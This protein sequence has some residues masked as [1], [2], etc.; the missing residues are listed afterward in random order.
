PTDDCTFWYTQ[1]YYQTTGSFDFNTRICSFKFADCGEA[2]VPDETPEISCTD[3]VDNDCDNL[4]DCS[5]SDCSDDPACICDND[6]VCETGEDCN[7]CSNDCI[8]G[9]IPGAVCGNGICEAGD[10]E[11]CLSCAADCNGTQNGRPSN[12]FCCGDGDGQNPVSC[13]DSRCTAGG[14]MCTDVPTTPGSYCCGDAT[15]EGAE[16][17]FNCEIDCGAAPFCGDGTCDPGEDQCSCTAD[18]GIPPG[19]EAGLCTDGID[20][21]CGGGIDCND[22]DCDGIDPACT[23]CEPKNASCSLDDDCCSGICKSN[24]R[25]R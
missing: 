7:N 23:I 10:G 25:C 8:S 19:S 18:C 3:G 5:D 11:D 15:C 22:L 16:D 17:S 9:S 1:E 14:L 6:G 20:N 13:S 24:G 21:D 4:V 2:C 12:R